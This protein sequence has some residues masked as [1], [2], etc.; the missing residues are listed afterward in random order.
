MTMLT[1][2]NSEVGQI[3]LFAV[4]RPIDAVSRDLRNTEKDQVIAS[5]LGT[6]V[7]TGTA[8][9]FPISDLEGVGLA[10]YLREGYAVT[11]AQIAQDRTRL[12]RLDGFVLLLF[13]SA[14]EGRETTLDIGSDL[15]LIGTY[16]EE[17]PAVPAPPLTAQSAEPYT[18]V[19]NATPITPPKGRAGAAIV[20]LGLI[21]L[22]GI[23]VWWLI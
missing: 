18:G 1:I 12:D 9:L 13:S 11:D 23:I 14:F 10:H 16:G 19:P 2:P 22:V 7:P 6:S 20:L 4:N 3:R 15:T 21:V 17:Q 8:E 5:L